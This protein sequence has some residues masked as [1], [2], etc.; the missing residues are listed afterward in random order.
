MRAATRNVLGHKL[1]LVL[2]AISIILGVAFVSGTFIL[3]D[4]MKSTFNAI[5]DTAQS[6]DVNVRGVKDSTAVA[7]PSTGNQ[8]TTL[9]LTL[10]DQIKTVPGVAA[11]EPELQG[12]AV[13]IGKNGKAAVNGGAPPFGFGWSDNPKSW[14]L[15][16]GHAP[17][18]GSEIAVEKETLSLAKLKV[19]DSTRVVVGGTVLP[20]TIVGEVQVPGGAGL[21]GATATL[22]DRTSAL[23]YYAEDGKVTAFDVTAASGVTPTQLRDRLATA[24]PNTDVVTGKQ[25]SDETKKDLAN[26][27]LKIFTIFFL[28]FAFIAVFVGAFVILNTFSMLVAQRTRELALLRALGASRRQVTRSVLIEAFIVGTFSSLVGLGLG[29][30]IAVGLKG[31]LGR[32][33]LKI[34]GG[35]PIEPRTVVWCFA[36]GIV[37]TLI[38]AYFPARRAARIPPV[39]AM[40]DD[41]AMPTRSL[42]RRAAVG[43]GLLVIGVVI[44][45]L[46]L[47]NSVGKAGLLT[48]LGAGLT[49]LAVTILAPI[50]APPVLRVLGLPFVRIWKT[51]GGLARSNAIRNPRRSA[52]TASA[53]MIGLA[54]VT[55][56][57]ILADSTKS[58]FAKAFNSDLTSQYALTAVG[59]GLVPANVAVQARQIPGV[60][61]VAEYTQIPIKIGTDDF[62]VTPANAADVAAAQRIDLAS[63]SV[64]ALDKGQILVSSKTAKSHHWSVGQ[65]LTGRVAAQS[66]PMVVGGIYTNDQLLGGIVVPRAWYDQ[67]VPAGQRVDFA[68]AVVTASGQT[69][70]A[71]QA[72][73]EKVVDPYAIV[74]VKTKAEYLKDRA[75]Q[76]NILLYIL[77]ALLGLAIIIAVFGII[78]TLALSVFERTREIG[79]LRAV[80]MG[81]GQLGGM[82]ILESVVISLFGAVLGV[83][84]GL[85][86]GIAVQRAL[87]GQGLDVLSIPYA[88]LVVFLVLSALGGVFAAIWPARRA[89]KLDVLRAITTE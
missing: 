37:V 47:S 29:A 82:V 45:I 71:V 11:V 52:A 13:L 39:A 31:L 63:G 41:V 59:N 43:S 26:G 51:T 67:A 5:A 14:T 21:A 68:I 20:V 34:Q 46:G 49:V 80:G 18:S 28:V 72:A 81:R 87:S 12:S 76:I 66:V 60:S 44:M 83:V 84:L 73:L 25:L 33:G 17:T 48:G 30:V 8:R 7:D 55:G 3:T 79:L 22:F 1:R 16:A 53:L 32:F 69:S 89:A 75:G 36:V 61:H 6:T 54:L 50:V 27:V 40:R 64:D 24:L 57:T 4:A 62:D 70:S 88:K 38:A 35:L 56:I 86:F 15:L 58:S 77:Y 65:T 42:K 2:T 10:A 74:T 23:K 78:N 19:G 9:P 85:Y